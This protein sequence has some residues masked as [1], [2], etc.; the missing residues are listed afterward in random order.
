AGTTAGGEWGHARA[1]NRGA[2]PDSPDPARNQVLRLLDDLGFAPEPSTDPSTPVR[3]A[4]CPLL[5]AAHREPE[6][7]CGVHLGIV[8][9]ALAAYGADPADSDLAPFAEPGACLLT[10]P[11]H[12]E[13]EQ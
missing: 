8:R 5:E 9:G 3:L 4:R 7:V 12:R 10:L 6:V 1:S 13:E 2:K 11:A